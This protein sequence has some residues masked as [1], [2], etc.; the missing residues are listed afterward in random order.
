MPKYKKDE[1]I[2]SK[3]IRNAKFL[4]QFLANRTDDVT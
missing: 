1:D 2:L 4:N 3:M